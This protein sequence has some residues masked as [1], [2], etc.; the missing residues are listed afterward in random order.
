MQAGDRILYLDDRGGR[1]LRVDRRK[2]FIPGFEPERRSWSDR[3]SNQ[4]R[5]TR[6]GQQYVDFPRRDI[7]RYMEFRNAT[8]GI[9]YALLMG[10][11]VW[12]AIIS[13]VMLW[14]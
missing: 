2:D 4:D 11:S 12:A 8:Q 3:R 1:R 14:S 10:T 13:F 7:D 9:T 5:R 6:D